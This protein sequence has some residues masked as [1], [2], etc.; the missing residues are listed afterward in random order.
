ME[1]K[2]KDIE[3]Y[4]QEKEYIDT[5][6]VPLVPIA[7]G[8]NMKQIVEKGEFI[9]LLSLHLERQFKGRMLFLPAF[10]YLSDSED[11]QKAERLQ[12]WEEKIKENGVRY[13]FYLTSDPSWREMEH[14]AQESLLF[15]PSIPLDHMDDQFKQSIMEDQVKELMKGIVKGWQD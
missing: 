12:E 14:F 9:Q 6:V 15:V 11:S 8:H 4:L 13:T 2:A 3:V 10:T 5:V 1:W 7:L